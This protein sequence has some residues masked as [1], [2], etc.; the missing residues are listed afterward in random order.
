MDLHFTSMKTR[1]FV[2]QSLNKFI[3]R[4]VCG[5]F[6]VKIVWCYCGGSTHGNMW[7]YGTEAKDKPVSS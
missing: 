7:L 6:A 2:Y 4:L 1:D 5:D 3:L